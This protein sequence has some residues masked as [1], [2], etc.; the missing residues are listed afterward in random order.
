MSYLGLS[1]IIGALALDTTVAFQMLISQPLFSCPIIGWVMGNPQLGFEMGIILQLLWISVLPIGAVTFPEGNVASMVITVLVIRFHPSPYPNV[2][3]AWAL[4]MGVVVS[5]LGE[6]MTILDRR[7][8]GYLF[9]NV[10]HAAEKARLQHIVA[11]NMLGILIYFAMTTLLSFFM[12]NFSDWALQHILMFVKPQ[13]DVWFSFLK[14]GIVGLGLALTIR[15]FFQWREKKAK[16]VEK[17][18]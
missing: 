13:W 6:W 8:N 12:L 11:I 1:L 16:T 9:E 18:H 7:L 17:V 10:V 5:L 2:V 15:L 14:P 4:I 3:F